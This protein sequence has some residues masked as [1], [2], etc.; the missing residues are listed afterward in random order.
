MNVH[1]RYAPLTRHLQQA[2][3]SEAVMTFE[4]IERLI[5]RALPPSA[6]GDYARHWWA[7]TVT[8][9][10]GKAWL[11]AGWRVRTLEAAKRRVHFVRSGD[12]PSP[13]SSASLPSSSAGPEL[14]LAALPPASRRMVEDYM[15]EAGIGFS[16]AVIALLQGLALERRRKLLEGF[17]GRSRPGSDSAQLIREDR[18]AR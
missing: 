15:E 6:T 12:A 8:H 3:S 5:G 4:E 1:T 16:E 14:T 11:D 13:G 7:N 2:A 9:S 17:I 10:Q 18:D